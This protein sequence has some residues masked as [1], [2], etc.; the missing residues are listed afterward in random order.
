MIDKFRIELVIRKENNR[1]NIDKFRNIINA[2]LVSDLDTKLILNFPT[3]W[4]GFADGILADMHRTMSDSMYIALAYFADPEEI[5]TDIYGEFADSFEAVIESKKVRK[6]VKKN[7][8]IINI[9]NMEENIFEVKSYVLDI[10]LVP[11]MVK[12]LDVYSGSVDSGIKLNHF[13]SGNR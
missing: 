1:D 2:Y 10:R 11:P 13:V 4:T 9:K 8:R 7:L 5:V 6:Y 12:I 3:Y